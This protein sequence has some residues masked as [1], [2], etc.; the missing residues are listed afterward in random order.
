MR[1]ITECF[2]ES[3]SIAQM[4]EAEQ[5]SEG[6][7]DIFAA[8][9]KKFHG[10]VQYLKGIAAKFGSYFIPINSNGSILPCISP[11]TA[12]QAY[13]DGAI[14]KDST[15]VV[16]DKEGARITGCRTKF[17]DASKLS[18][19]ATASDS[20]KYWDRCAALVG[21]SKATTIDDLMASEDVNESLKTFLDGAHSAAYESM[22]NEVKLHTDDPQAVYNIIEDDDDLKHEIK[23]A[24]KGN[25]AR[26][27]IW[28]APGIGKSA[29]LRN[30]LRELKGD[31]P[32]YRLIVKT[33]S[34]ETPDNFTLPTYVYKEDG[35][36]AELETTLNDN[37][38]GN[39]KYSTKEKTPIAATDVPKTWMPVYKPTGDELMDEEMD[40]A[41]GHGLLFIDE[42]SRATPQVLNV[43]LPLVN[44]GDFNGYKLGSGWSI[45]VASNREEDEE[46]GQSNIGNAL[47]NRFA[48]VYYEPTC[49]TWRKWADKQGFMSPLLLQ[50]LSMPEHENLSGGKFYYWDFNESGSSIN[51]TKLMCT[52]RSWTN[53]MRELA[54]YAHTGTLEGFSIFDIPERVVKRVLN[55]NVPKDAV[56]GFWAFLETVS[57]IGDFDAAVREVWT[58]AGKGL[59]IAKKDL[60]LITLPL[61]QLVCS[62]HSDK[63]PSQKEWES[64]CDW[65][66]AQ[67][68]DQLASAVLDVYKNVFCGDVKENLQNGIFI[69][70]LVINNAKNDPS[71]INLYRDAY[72]KFTSRW[73]IKL[74]EI[75][76]YSKGLDKLSKTY[77]ATFKATT[78]NGMEGLG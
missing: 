31:F 64:L 4:I 55:K 51:P 71:K 1:S 28:G 76:D 14:K 39:G 20:K 32:D 47:A 67:K 27:M 5:V 11:L 66:V 65:M 75:P 77:G 62:A 63:L 2:E 26:L 22:I 16:L 40:A 33:L 60:S 53:A 13:K 7:K 18:V 15:M 45:V 34:N 17:D 3:R 59:T 54:T 58:N 49:K 78:I 70:Q 8:I 10:A 19:Y 38:S 52:P 74:E 48:Q 42:L 29:I 56:D 36:A 41:L 69:M 68:S 30:V 50:W 21:E 43:V 35:T 37:G 46:S 57:K 6:L 12:G 44:E 61:A 24:I 72:S 23:V 73:G 9:K 25:S